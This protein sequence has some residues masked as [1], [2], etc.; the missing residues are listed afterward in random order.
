[1]G[2]FECEGVG[3][4]EFPFPGRTSFALRIVSFLGASSRSSRSRRPRRPV[5]RIDSKGKQGLYRV[6]PASV[7]F[8]CTILQVP[9]TV[10]NRRRI[11]RPAH[12]SSVGLQRKCGHGSD[13]QSSLVG[14]QL[15]RWPLR[16]LRAN[17]GGSIPTLS[18]C[19]DE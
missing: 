7:G 14:L 1:M 18:S 10:V 4:T 8:F 3:A 5:Q 17:R 6:G 9:S 16:V 15:E 12:F 13:L 11:G 19:C 2:L